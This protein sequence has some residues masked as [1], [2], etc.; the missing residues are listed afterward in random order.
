MCWVATNSAGSSCL[1]MCYLV[2]AVIYFILMREELPALH[3]IN[4]PFSAL[5]WTGNSRFFYRV[6]YPY[7]IN[8]PKQPSDQGYR[9]LVDVRLCVESPEANAAVHQEWL[10]ISAATICNFIR[11]KYTSP[12]VM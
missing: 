4:R 10:C 1:Q 8:K 6:S 3:V 5:Y 2:F 7:S 9:V 11:K 12:L